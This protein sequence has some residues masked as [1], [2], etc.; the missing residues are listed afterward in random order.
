MPRRN[1]WRRSRRLRISCRPWLFHI[2]KNET[3]L[4]GNLAQHHV[5]LV[6]SNTSGRLLTSA[7]NFA[8]PIGYKMRKRVH[9]RNLTIV[10]PMESSQRKSCEGGL[11]S[12]TPQWTGG[13][14]KSTCQ[15]SRSGEH[16]RLRGVGRAARRRRDSANHTSGGR[17]SDCAGG[18]R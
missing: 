10:S 7:T 18:D 13:L 3:V 4:N 5:A 6:T 16:A 8:C 12:H 14:A 9:W 1:I 11:W 15:R 2:E 17:S